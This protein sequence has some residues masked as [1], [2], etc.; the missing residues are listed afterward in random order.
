MAQHCVP[1]G[2]IIKVIKETLSQ[3][4]LFLW[5]MITLAFPFSTPRVAAKSIKM[6]FLINIL[7]NISGLLLSITY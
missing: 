5:N 4:D 1:F 6:I 2:Y 3:N 7:I